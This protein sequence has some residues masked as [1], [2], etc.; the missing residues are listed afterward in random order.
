VKA[1]VADC[2][3]V[4][5]L[6]VILYVGEST[7]FPQWLIKPFAILGAKIYGGFHLLETDAVRAVRQAKVPIL[8]IHGEADK[9]VPCHMSAEAQKA[10]PQMV[11]RYTF[12]DAAH[13]ISYLVD[14]EKYHKIVKDFLQKV[15]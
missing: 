11:S 13:G 4:N 7:A 10:N 3:Y 6:D 9:Y 14:T 15:V 5:P 8:I 12:P 1:I 2:P